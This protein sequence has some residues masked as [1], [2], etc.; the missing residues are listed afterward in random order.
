M[1]KSKRYLRRKAA[2]RLPAPALDLVGRAILQGVDRA[3]ADRWDRAVRVAAEAKGDTAE[4]RVRAINRRF[5]RELSTMGAATGAV[6]ATPGLGTS[7]A[8][9]TLVAD[10][11]WFAVRSADLVMTIGAANGRT[12]ATVEERRAWVLSVLAFGEA[13]AEEFS[14]L[15]IEV[16]AR[17]VVGGERISGRL[18]G[19]AG[20]DVAT[21]DALRRLN[22]R[23]AAHVVTKFGSRRSLL[24][25]GKLLPFGVGA[26]VG[27][28]ANYALIRVVGFHAQR[29]FAYSGALLPPPPP[30]PGLPVDSLVEQPAP[31]LPPVSPPPPAPGSKRLP[32]PPVKLSEADRANSIPTDSQPQ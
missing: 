4:K 32:N 31:A 24:A 5:R 9:A 3:V 17:A 18:A 13:A 8:A 28:S 22:A 1:S 6:A 2:A 30:T 27:G 23:L 20:G 14:S 12:D 29:F 19:I 15:L 7:A 25:V 10:L 26:M 16:D 11:T 21:L